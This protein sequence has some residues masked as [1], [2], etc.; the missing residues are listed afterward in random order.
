MSKQILI[1]KDGIKTT[2]EASQVENIVQ[3]SEQI[4]VKLKNGEQIIL[5]K[6]EKFSIDVLENNESILRLDSS[7]LESLSE[8]EKFLAQESNF[9]FDNKF[10]TYGGGG[11]LTAG[12][13]AVASSGGGGSTSGDITP[14]TILTQEL[15]V[16]NKT[17]TGMTEANATVMVSYKGKVIGT[18]VA[19]AEGKYSITLDK[20]YSNGEKLEVIATD[21]ANNSTGPN[22]ITAP[23]TTAP[24]SLTQVISADGKTVT[25]QTEAGATVTA[26]HNGK[27]VG[28]AVAGTDGQY[29]LTLNPAFING[30]SL[31]VTATDKAN[32]S[33]KP[34]TIIAPD[35][36]APAT[37]TQ[38]LAVDNKT[39]T[40]MTEANATVTVSY[41]GK[42]IG[43]A[44]AD[45]EGKYSVTLDKAYR[46]GEKLEVVATDTAN[47]STKANTVTAPDTTAPAS[48]TQVI[49]ANGQTIT[50]KTEAGATVAA[51]FNGQVVGTAIAGTDGQY[52]LTLTPAFTNGEQLAV[53]ATD[54][55]NNSTQPNTVTAPDTTA[56]ATLIQELAADNKT[57]TGATEANATVT[58]S[59]NGK[60]IGTAVAD[61]NGN[62]SVTLDKAYRNGEKLEV[63]ATDTANNSTKANTV[64]APDTT[65]PASL[66]QQISANGQTI[67]GKTEAGATVTAMHNGKVVGTAVA[68]TDGQYTLTL[69]PA[70][71]NGEQLAVIA[72]D[73]AN[74]STQP[75]T[76]TA[77]DT[78]APVNLTQI[79]VT[80]NKTVTGSTEA[81]A[82]VTVSYNGKVIGTAVADA[83]G[84]YSV[85]LD[86]AYRNGEK[87]EVV[88]T[89]TANN[90]TK[91][92]AV[93]APDTTAPSSL[94][95]VISADGQTIT[96]KTEAGATVTAMHNGKVVGTAVA[97]TDGQYTLTLN[98]AFTNGEQ[99]A[100][101]ATDKANNSTQPNTVTAPDTTAPAT[102][103]QEL[104]ADNKTVTGATEANATVTVSY[105]GK[106]IGTAVADANGN[107]SVTLDKAYRNGEKLE[108]V[109]T[110]TANNSTKANTVTAPDTT[111]PAS[112]TQQISANGQTITGKTEAGATVTAMH[113]GKVVG[114]AVAGT[115]G[116]YTL[117]LNPA[118]TNGEQLAVIATDKANNSTQPNTVT[119]PDT[120]A[121]V[122]LTQILVT[123]NK[124]VTGSTEA[125]ATVTVSYNGKVIGTAV[126]D[127]NGNYSVTLD[128]A[129]RNGEKLEVVAT[130]TANNSTKPNAVTAP[131][132]TAPSSLTQVISA[133]GQTIT[134]KT[135][136]GATVTAMHNGKVVGTAVAGTDGQYTLTLNPAFTNGEQLAVIATDKANNSTQPNTVT[137][138]DTTAPATLIQELA[139]DN[140]TVTGATE[141]NAT[142]TVSYNGKVIGTAVADA[143]GNYSVTLDKAY[144]NG[145]KLEVVATDTANN[146]TKANTV[147][148]PDTTAPASLTQQISANGQTITGKTEAGATVTAMHNGK[149]VGTAVAGTD[150]QYTL[151]LNPAFT[152][153]EQLA[154]IATDKANNST[155]PNTVT[156][157]DTTAPATLIQEL[158]ADNKTVTGATEANATVTVSYNGKVIG[159]AVADANGNY[160]VTLDKA[161]RNGEKLEVVAKDQAGNATHPNAITAPDTT[162]PASLTQAISANGQTITGKTEAGATVTAMHN[163][164]V[165]GTAV[166]GTDGQY[167]LTL[168][169]AFTNGEQLAVIATDK[170]N[171]S[172][173]PNTVTAPDSTAPATLTQEL[174]ADNKTVSGTTEAGATVTVSYNGKVVGT[175]VADANGKYSVTLNKA[176]NNGEKLE[177]VA[178]DQADNAVT[179]NLYA[180]IAQLENADAHFELA[181]IFE[182]QTVLKDNIVY[183]QQD[184][185]SM[186]VYVNFEVTDENASIILSL[187]QASG[188]INGSYNY[189]IDGNG[190]SSSGSKTISSLGLS[191]QDIILAEGL[192]PGHYILQ[193]DASSWNTDFELIVKQ[194]KLVNELVFEG[195]ETVVGHIFA[196]VNGKVSAPQ[197]YILKV[198]DQEIQIE[199]GK[200]NVESI[201]YQTEHGYLILKADGSYTYQSSWSESGLNAKGLNDQL[202]IEIIS[203]DGQTQSDYQVYIT[204]DI[205]PPV[206]GELIFTDFEDSGISAIDGITN[207]ASFDLSIRGN[208]L[209]STVEYQYSTDGSVTWFKLEHQFDYWSDGFNFFDEG[210]YNFRA[211]VTDFVGNE[212]YTDIKT[213]TVDLTAPEL[214]S[215]FSYDA[216]NDQVIFNAPTDAY[217]VYKWVNDEWQAVK[218][219]NMV[220]W[221]SAKYKV[222]ATDVAGNIAEKIYNI[223]EVSGTYKPTDTSEINILKAHEVTGWIGGGSGN[224]ILLG[225]GNQSF[226]DGQEGDD[227]L[228]TQG[229]NGSLLYGGKGNDLYI[230]D[231][232]DIYNDQNELI[233]IRDTKSDQERNVLL[234]KGYA[235]SEVILKQAGDTLEIYVNGYTKPIKVSNQFAT[236]SY[237]LNEGLT[238]IEFDDGTILDRKTILDMLVNRIEGTDQNDNLIAEESATIYGYDGDD[239]IEVKGPNSYVYGGSGND[240]L[241]G[242][243][244]DLGLY[245]NDDYLYGG[246][247][248]DILLGGGGQSFLYGEEGDDILNAQGGS[249]SLLSGGAGSDTYI[250]DKA[251]IYKDENQ[252]ITI[253]DSNSGQDRNIL[254]LKGYA[255]SEIV[256]KQAGNHLE[257]DIS[258][259]TKPIQVSNQFA[260]RD[261]GLTA[262][263]FDDGTIWDRETILNKVN[264]PQHAQFSIGEESL[265]DVLSVEDADLFDHSADEMLFNENLVTSLLIESTD[266]EID[267][268]Q[269]VGDVT[270]TTASASGIDTAT[271]VSNYRVDVYDDLLMPNTMSI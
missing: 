171:N 193:L 179:K 35:T 142:V 151:T 172:T 226:L 158:A 247:G 249:T 48:L 213:I 10:I 26:M 96:G 203:M 208:E 271:L 268:T 117:T 85:T 97:G 235:V 259:Y 207:D 223:G 130:D 222:I 210:K 178:K 28:T 118:F 61:A 257:I 181:E 78:T 176:Y 234:L 23:D 182:T 148:A 134:G 149:V 22:S 156:A 92:N 189:S 75:N 107:Y 136:A 72:T 214:Q 86:K 123:D 165:V 114:T 59:Y 119:A 195:Y 120:T 116:Q 197:S 258:D 135:E 180:P 89:D 227:I 16:D 263:E 199:N 145:E 228:N 63:V 41:N 80:D 46:N 220:G 185:S 79:L 217:E 45:A 161:Y 242:N 11:L 239:Y 191:Y 47:N 160:S 205:T 248:N 188:N 209:N 131:D 255:V 137:A 53:I 54:K 152:N 30:E 94:T 200:G 29:T 62:Y 157:P 87:L 154:V 132:T 121:P 33:T 83:N 194:E 20:A 84:N 215:V 133:D 88:A 163:G 38:E 147:T 19:D 90:S 252:L 110:D 246:A 183:S 262:I 260:M 270:A 13:A 66:T 58:V 175:A 265:H 267:L 216:Q 17:V 7:N 198:G 122:N 34:N 164:K 253:N 196:D 202:N 240:T 192:A 111:A 43:T 3:Q 190:F 18:A 40:G 12:V 233:T 150:G 69:N 125:G 232:A 112:L 64:T 269:F 225:G 143:N 261:E 106:V 251:D 37:L 70:F 104:A 167:T 231:K 15:A 184:Q 52:T 32:N 74:N 98:P 68:G 25:G 162:A 115:D 113:N 218:L 27:V 95:Q 36:T 211:K 57:V 124:T 99:L 243:S 21:K 1:L 108:V 264:A 245:D 51:T 241:V 144:R 2:L 206:A 91:P 170:A 73:K 8:L 67:T 24:V 102:L 126:A 230:F 146:S 140:K 71:T 244:Y 105:N 101:I 82:T 250:F 169:P 100:V 238:A 129:Y 237:L 177:V 174:A 128:K 39:V 256:L 168:N 224:D 141:A 49:S 166:A 155:Q 4:V 139:A 14:P 159:T 60:V 5:S 254:Q 236:E 127:A 153:G 6:N 173:Q 219:N 186:Y 56:P 201:T 9:W 44:V 204:T 187:T 31:Q 42:V 93:T 109:A 76:V 103:I 221:E 229:G 81:G 138:P 50:G 65:A 55:A 77:P 212:S 266:N